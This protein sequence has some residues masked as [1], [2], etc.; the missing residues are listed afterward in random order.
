MKIVGVIPCRW[1]SSR[2]PGKPLA[3]IADK[4]MMWHV[5]K[6][7]A[8]STVLD[9]LVIATDDNRIYDACNELDLDAVYTRQSHKTGTDR[10]GEV[11]EKVSGDIF[12]NIQGDEPLID[13]AGI[14]AVASSLVRQK[15]IAICNGYTPMTDDADVDNPNVVKVITDRKGYALAYSRSRIP[16]GKEANPIY[17]R[18]LGLYAMT[19]EAVLRFGRLDSGYLENS[20]GVEMYR[21]LENGYRVLMVE[22]NDSGSIP[23]DLPGDIQ[24][25]EQYMVEH[26]WTDE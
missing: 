7:A 24:R 12:V 26:G 8:K 19:R 10:V 5:W 23:V 1:A 9:K 18:Q 16:Y 20:E 6:Q 25:V 13:P 3:Q 21:Y 17:K 22:I 4:P 2:F 15:D 14:D 11:A